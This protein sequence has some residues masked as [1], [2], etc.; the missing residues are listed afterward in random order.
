MSCHTW[1]PGC[2]EGNMHLFIYL[3]FFTF[4]ILLICCPNEVTRTINIISPSSI[5]DGLVFR[6][7]VAYHREPQIL[8]E[9]LTPEGML[10][11]R[12]NAEA[13][14]LELE[15]LQKPFLTSTLHG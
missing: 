12:D 9:S 5:Q 7:Q 15:T 2:V 3:L 1:L 14:A 10:I 8:R 13:Q 4:T 6:V 11:Y